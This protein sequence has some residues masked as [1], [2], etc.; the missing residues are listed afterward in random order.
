MTGVSLL[1]ALGAVHPAPLLAQRSVAD[2][3]FGGRYVRERQRKLE[4]VRDPFSDNHWQ[5]YDMTTDRGE[6][7]DVAAQRPEVVARLAAEWNTYAKRVG[8]VKLDTPMPNIYFGATDSG[9]AMPGALRS[10]P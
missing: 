4:S 10:A 9:F 3:L 7:H 2:E 5:L 8:V 6:T 1:S